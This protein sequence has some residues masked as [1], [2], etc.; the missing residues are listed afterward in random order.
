MDIASK[1]IRVN[2]RLE[3]LIYKDCIVYMD[4]I[5]IFSTSLEEHMIS[6]CKVFAK[7]KEASL[8]L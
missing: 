4:D 1:V 7:L 2:N 8:K 6:L 3:D 5:T